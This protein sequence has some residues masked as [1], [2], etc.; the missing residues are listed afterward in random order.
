MK[1]GEMPE[2][3]H[4]SV[5]VEKGDWGCLHCWTNNTTLGADMSWASVKLHLKE[6]C[7]IRSIGV[8]LDVKLKF[9]GHRHDVDKPTENDYY[10]VRPTMQ[11][12][13]FLREA[14]TM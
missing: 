8:S 10:C 13:F 4:P 5:R 1:P 9:R 11:S 6:K 2:F 14:A 12:D 7:V 3:K